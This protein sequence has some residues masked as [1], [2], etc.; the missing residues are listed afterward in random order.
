MIISMFVRHTLESG[1][2]NHQLASAVGV[3]N[4]SHSSVG[5]FSS[6]SSAHWINS[7]LYSYSTWG[8]E[9]SVIFYELGTSIR[10]L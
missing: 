7:R 9:R 3:N 5:R 1:W 8:H 6:T 2:E 4:I 10:H